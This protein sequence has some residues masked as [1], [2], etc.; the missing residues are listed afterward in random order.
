M[1]FYKILNFKFLAVP[2]DYKIIHCIT[3]AETHPKLKGIVLYFLMAWHTK[4]NRD[5]TTADLTRIADTN[6]RAFSFV[7]IW[8]RGKASTN[9]INHTGNIT[10]NRL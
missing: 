1:L 9:Q 3:N 6:R 8:Q 7:S 10:L 4:T 5:G 2:F